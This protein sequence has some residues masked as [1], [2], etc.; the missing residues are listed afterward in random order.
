MQ[1]VGLGPALH[2]KMPEYQASRPE[3]SHPAGQGSAPAL[4]LL[5]V[6][7]PQ[8]LQ[9]FL[10]QLSLAR[11][12]QLQQRTRNWISGAV[13]PVHA[14]LHH[15]NVAQFAEP[16]KQP[17]S[18]LLHCLPRGIGIKDGNPSGQ[19]ATAAKRDPQVMNRV[20]RKRGAYPVA[21]LEHALYPES[22]ADFVLNRLFHFV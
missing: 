6:E 3:P 14:L 12:D 15:V 9:S 16:A 7:F 11:T 1:F 19:R 13:Q 20:G 4:P 17:L 21:F 18:C 10:L 22:Q 2:G 8:S 5:A